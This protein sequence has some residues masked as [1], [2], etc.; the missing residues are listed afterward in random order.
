MRPVRY[1]C[2]LFDGTRGAVKWR[3]I[4]TLLVGVEVMSCQASLIYGR[5]VKRGNLSPGSV[6]RGAFNAGIAHTM[7]RFT[8]H[9]TWMT[10][11]FNFFQR[12]PKN[13]EKRSRE[14]RFGIAE[15]QDLAPSSSSTNPNC[16]WL[17]WCSVRVSGNKV[18]GLF[19]VVRISKMFTTGQ[20]RHMQ[21]IWSGTRS[22]SLTTDSHSQLDFILASTATQ[23]ASQP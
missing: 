1:G 3:M 21:Y 7:G 20:T 18:Y 12:K 5:D 14:R 8:Q 22:Q 6:S 19:I 9:A 10:T 16:F 2:S 15:S 11:C 17:F 23:E 4:F 13:D